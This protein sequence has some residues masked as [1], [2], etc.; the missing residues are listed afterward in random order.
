MKSHRRKS[1]ISV[2]LL[3]FM[4]VLVCS[5]SSISYYHQSVAGHLSLMSDRQPIAELISSESTDADK[6][7]LFEQVLKIRAFA[8]S[9]LGLPD[10]KSYT[11]Y[12]ELEREY[13]VW[14]V[15]ATPR[16]S[17]KP[18][19][20]CF[21]VAGCVS[22]RGYYAKAEAEQFAQQLDALGND[23]AISGASAYSTLGWFDDPVISTMLDR[24]EI[25]LAETIFHE[26]AH[27]V[28]YLKKDSAFNEAFATAVAIEGVRQWL[29]ET[30]PE[31]LVSY[32]QH[33]ER[34]L[35]FNQ[36]IDVTSTNLTA[37]YQQELS[38][39]QK[40]LEKRQVFKDLQTRYQSFK[41][42]SNNFSGYDRWFAQGL[43]NA[44]LT[45]ISTY[46]KNVPFV[47]NWLRECENKL[48]D[49]YLKMQELSQGNQQLTDD[50]RTLEPNC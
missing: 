39:E 13:V 47:E 5:C 29:Q 9:Q 23:I 18:T 16:F 27:Q 26:L 21:P 44:H 11:S 36:L 14:N 34:R 30:G 24:G 35:A 40:A 48:P 49:F 45:M 12:V 6:K 25:I 2:L 3:V 37:I 10:N 33:L 43:N 20:W 8:S 7:R 1:L 17:L 4:I 32:E 38:A 31:K 15:V 42:E 41:A 22:Y 28:L 19:T 46:W 50:L